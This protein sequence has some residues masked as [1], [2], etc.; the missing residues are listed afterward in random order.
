MAKATGSK[1]AG[2]V[3]L[4]KAEQAQILEGFDRLYFLNPCRVQA[5]EI[6]AIYKAIW[7]KK[8]FSQVGAWGKWARAHKMPTLGAA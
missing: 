4:T 5:D 3:Q 2:S 1:A 7:P 6:A 8:D